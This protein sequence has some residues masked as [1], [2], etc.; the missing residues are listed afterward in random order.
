MSDDDWF[1]CLRHQRV[2]RGE[3]A[4]EA[5]QRLGPYPSEAAARAWKEQ[6]EARNEAW[7][8]EDRRWEGEED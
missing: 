3:E 7:D 1:W 8:Q 6:V 5:E 4:C 2:E